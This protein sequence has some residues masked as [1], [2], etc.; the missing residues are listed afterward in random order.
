M[1]KLPNPRHRARERAGAP[2]V[3]QGA[4]I[5]GLL[6]MGVVFMRQ[7]RLL[8]ARDAEPTFAHDVAP[9]LYANCTTC[10]R[11]GGL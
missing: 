9:I 6:L 8:G 5:T 10:H 3:M 11:P 7:P 2:R 4:G 1:T